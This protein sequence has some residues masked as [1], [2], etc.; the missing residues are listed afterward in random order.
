MLR[1]C[2]PW[3]GPRSS[4]GQGHRFQGPPCRHLSP[5]LPWCCNPAGTSTVLQT[6]AACSVHQRHRPGC[7][8]VPWLRWGPSTHGTVGGWNGRVMGRRG[9]RTEGRWDGEGMRHLGAR[10]ASVVRGGRPGTGPT[11]R[12]PGRA[13]PAGTGGPAGTPTVDRRAVRSVWTPLAGARCLQRHV[14]G[15]RPGQGPLCSTP[16]R[17]AGEVPSQTQH[18]G[19][20]GRLGPLALWMETSHGAATADHSAAIPQKARHTPPR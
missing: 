18:V 20:V 1:M 8:W 9:D 3:Q 14:R 19:G 10:G 4:L 15:N 5:H 7:P 16:D 6:G 17:R 2:G 13:G 11:A 12:T